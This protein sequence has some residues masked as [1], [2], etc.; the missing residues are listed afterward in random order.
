MVTL[1]RVECKNRILWTT[2]KRDADKYKSEHPKSTITK[3]EFD[4]DVWES[5]V[6]LL[7]TNPEIH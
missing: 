6:E 4:D 7:D 5:Y 3:H 1:W 2:C